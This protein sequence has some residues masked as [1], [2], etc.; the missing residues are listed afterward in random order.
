MQKDVYFSSQ[1]NLF[2]EIRMGKTEQGGVG[3]KPLRMKIHLFGKLASQRIFLVQIQMNER[4][5][6][7]A[8]E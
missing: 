5:L 6:R 4:Q 1:C 2:S 7:L 3:G 8:Q